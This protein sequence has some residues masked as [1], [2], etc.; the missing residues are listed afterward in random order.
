MFEYTYSEYNTVKEIRNLAK[1]LCYQDII[2]LPDG[3]TVL[4]TRDFRSKDYVTLI[5]YRDND[6][7]ATIFQTIYIQIFDFAINYLSTRG[8]THDDIMTK[9]HKWAL[10]NL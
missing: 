6:P 7:I 8:Y 5:C 2:M 1:A 10:L 9:I 3:I 4:N